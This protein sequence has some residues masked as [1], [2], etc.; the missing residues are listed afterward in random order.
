VKEK[1]ETPNIAFG[2]VNLANA[3]GTGSRWHPGSGGWPTIRY[4]NAE[5]GYEGAPY[6]QKTQKPMCDELGDVTNMRAYVDEKS[7]KPCSFNYDATTLSLTSPTQNCN[8]QETK[9]I[10][11]W[12]AKTATE[13]SGELARLH[14]MQTS[15]GT[16]LKPA[17][18]TW[19]T[20]RVNIL[21]QLSSAPSTTT[22]AEKEL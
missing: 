1:F 6:V 22:G 4:F 18:K 17:Q 19:L 5:T 20:Q 9:F 3:P 12:Q 15:S 11:Q 8:E 14:K 16:S 13:I 10:E 7:V 21:K 2:D